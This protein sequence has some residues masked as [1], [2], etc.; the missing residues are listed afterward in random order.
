MTGSMTDLQNAISLDERD[1]A[2]HPVFPAI[3]GNTR[4][5]KIIREGELVIQ[6]LEKVS[7]EYFHEKPI[8]I[9]EES[10]DAMTSRS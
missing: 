1:H 6:Q 8:V 10:G 2:L 7:Q 3:K 5:H 4:R 9:C